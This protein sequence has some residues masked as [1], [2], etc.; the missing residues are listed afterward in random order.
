MR[1][2]ILMTFIVTF[3][4]SA[5]EQQV[6]SEQNVIEVHQVDNKYLYESWKFELENIDYSNG[7]DYQEAN[8]IIKNFAFTP[9]AASCGATGIIVDYGAYWKVATY[10][11][12]S[13][14][15]GEAIF[16]HKKSGKMSQDGNVLFSHP[17]KMKMSYLEGT[18]LD[19]SVVK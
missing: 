16:I 4:V 9:K 5:H 11:G 8:I 12:F 19:I 10:E 18:H 17:N 2:F 14:T 15:P 3:W 1:Y 6:L 13:A 7:I